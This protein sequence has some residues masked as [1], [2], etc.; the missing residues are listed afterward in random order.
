MQDIL[1]AILTSQ[2]LQYLII[3]LTHSVFL[4][5]IAGVRSGKHEK[6]LLEHLLLN[7]NNLERP[8]ENETDTVLVKLG[9]TL[10]QIIDVVSIYCCRRREYILL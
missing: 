7:Y 6:R 3:L 2:A 1:I 10:Q 4:V 9:M 5:S 8:T